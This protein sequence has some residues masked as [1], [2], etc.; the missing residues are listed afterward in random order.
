M[1]TLWTMMLLTGLAGLVLLSAPSISYAAD[2]AIA[3]TQVK[4]SAEGP[5]F[6]DPA[7]GDLGSQVKKQV[8]GKNFK[9]VGTASQSAAEG[10]STDFVLANGMSLTVKV[11]SVKDKT[12]KLNLSIPNVVSLSV[13]VRNNATFLTNVPWGKDKLVLAI[14]PSL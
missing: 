7:L 6:V 3:V 13:D 2:V 11:L 10:K 8:P 14:R 12:I 4:A 5:D 9:L 1:R